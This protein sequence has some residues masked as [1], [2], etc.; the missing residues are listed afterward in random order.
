MRM[1]HNR[2]DIA[3]KQEWCRGWPPCSSRRTASRGS[4]CMTRQFL[5]GCND[6]GC[7]PPEFRPHRSWLQSTHLADTSPARV[8]GIFERAA[9]GQARDRS[10]GPGP[11]N[12]HFAGQRGRSHRL[13]R[14]RVTFGRRYDATAFHDLGPT[15]AFHTQQRIGPCHVGHF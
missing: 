2:E 6:P 7:V 15:T 1:K 3:G 11:I 12:R 5:Q 14:R 13:H 10:S 8:A 4:E 9:L